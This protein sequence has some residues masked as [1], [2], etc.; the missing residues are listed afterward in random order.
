MCYYGGF[1]SRMGRG[2]GWGDEE[3]EPM[4]AYVLSGFGPAAIH[5]KHPDLPLSS[6]KK[7]C[8]NM[9]NGDYDTHTMLFISVYYLHLL[10]CGSFCLWNC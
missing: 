2:V 1:C 10:L 3:R 4:K 7:L 5:G 6:I 9:K 8:A